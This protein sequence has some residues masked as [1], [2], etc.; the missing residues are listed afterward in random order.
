MAAES[1][2]SDNAVNHWDKPTIEIFCIYSRPSEVGRRPIA[3]AL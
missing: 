1:L 2:R 3:L